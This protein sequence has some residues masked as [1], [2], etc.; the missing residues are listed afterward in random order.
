MT[1][2]LTFNS[3]S[4]LLRVGMALEAMGGVLG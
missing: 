1:C 2:T 3:F 4:V